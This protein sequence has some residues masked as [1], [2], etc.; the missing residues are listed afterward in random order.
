MKYFFGKIHRT[1]EILLISILLYTTSLL[2]V[3]PESSSLIDYDRQI[4]PI[5][6]GNCYA[7]HG[8]DENKRMA[9]LRLDKEEA[10]LSKLSS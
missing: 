2:A 1:K 6:S 5:L 4:R 7:C 8:P 9:D 3:Q 10:A